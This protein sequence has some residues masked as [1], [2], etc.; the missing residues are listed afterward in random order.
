VRVTL[1]RKRLRIGDVPVCGR[2]I[3]KKKKIRQAES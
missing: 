3:Q 2:K 1:H